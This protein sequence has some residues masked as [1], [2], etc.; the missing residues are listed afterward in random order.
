MVACY[1][2]KN[3]ITLYCKESER[4][5]AKKQIEL[6]QRVRS[7]YC[8]ESDRVIAK[9]RIALLRGVRSRYCKESDRVIA[10]SQIELLQRV[11]SSYCKESDRVIAKSQIELLQRVRSRYC[12]ESDRVIAKSRI[13]LLRGVRSRYCK[14]SDRVIAKSRIELLQ[15]VGSR[16]CKESDRVI[17]KSQIALLQRVRSG[18]CKESD[19]VIAKSQIA[20]LQRVR[21]SY[22]KESDRVI[23]KSQIGLLQRVRSGYYKESDRVIAKSRIGLLQR[24]GSSYCKESDRVIAKSRIG[25]L[26]RVGSGYCKE[27]DRVIAKSRIELLQRVRSGYYKESDRVIAKSR[28]ELLQ[29]VRSS[30]YKESDRVIARSQI[31]LLQRVGS[32][33]CKESDR[34]ITKSQIELLQGVG[35]RYYK[36]S[37][38]QLIAL[39]APLR[40]SR[41][42]TQNVIAYLRTLKTL[43]FTW[44]KDLVCMNRNNDINRYTFDE[45]CV[46]GFFLALAVIVL[47]LLASPVGQNLPGLPRIQALSGMET[48][49]VAPQQHWSPAIAQRDNQVKAT[50]SSEE[51]ITELSRRLIQPSSNRK[52]VYEAPCDNRKNVPACVGPCKHP[53]TYSPKQIVE[54]LT[55]SPELTLDPNTRRNIMSLGDGIPDSD[56]IIA[57]AVSSNHFDEMQAMFESLHEKIYPVL[58]ERMEATKRNPS[59]LQQQNKV[60]IHNFTVALF[61]IGLTPQQRRLTEKNCRCKVLTFRKEMFP[62]HVHENACYS[63]KPLI[64][65]AVSQHARKL[66]LWQDSSVRWYAGFP[67]S[68][69]KAYS[70]GHQVIRYI[71]SH[72]I[73]ANTLKEMFDYM[74][75]D[76]C[77]Y[78]PYPEIQGNLHIHRSDLFNMQVLFE[79]WARCAIE[80]Q[81][82]CPRPPPSVLSCSQGTLHRCHRFDQSSMGILLS[83]IYQKEL[84]KIMFQE[85]VFDQEKGFR[86]SRGST[87]R[88]Y[89]KS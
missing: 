56:L 10:K 75:E 38:R 28:I 89:F 88:Y 40:F 11:R 69:D 32:S 42:F 8:K 86:V 45:L 23:A 30:Y 62:T 49:S 2:A 41:S 46:V 58:E 55:K 60:G 59:L 73:P 85:F 79:P 39:S 53:L 74:H 6:L 80:K 15:R 3:E 5:I 7:R 76:A 27:S 16:Y 71:N 83:R 21:S 84:Y 57:S 20:L 67:D 48:P 36:E 33:Y 54:K 64:I 63:W 61:D 43:S 34:V 37:D 66:V 31:E 1:F 25:L 81:C 51:L 35:S 50:L 70:V 4:V 82:M 52:V 47:L 78:L 72:R 12:K 19:R 26:Q 68:L 29:G 44:R 9:S 77:G 18:Y 65:M 17:A 87:N 13:A 14:E 24:V 22:Y